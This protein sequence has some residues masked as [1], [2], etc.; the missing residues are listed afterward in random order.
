MTNQDLTTPT[1]SRYQKRL[2]ART[3]RNA[4]RRG[5]MPA[6]VQA[7]VARNRRIAAAATHNNNLI[8][9]ANAGDVIAM[10]IIT[11]GR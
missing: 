8:V 3:R 11:G 1:T 4:I 7:V 6:S 2:A 9:A 10:Q 5:Q